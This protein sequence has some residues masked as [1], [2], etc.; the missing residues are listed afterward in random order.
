[1]EFKFAKTYPLEVKT[2]FNLT[3]DDPAIIVKCEPLSAGEAVDIR[4]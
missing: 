4:S 1:M 3:N 2:E